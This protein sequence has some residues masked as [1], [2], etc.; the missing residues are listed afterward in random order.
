MKKLAVL[1]IL[2]LCV[3]TLGGCMSSG[4]GSS[5]AD[6]VAFIRFDATDD[7]N[8]TVD[9]DGKVI[10]VT[11]GVNDSTPITKNETVYKDT[12]L[13]EKDLKTALKEIFK[14]SDKTKSVGIAIV[15]ATGKEDDAVKS[16]KD[17]ISQYLD[18][19]F[20]ANESGFDVKIQ[21]SIDGKNFTDVKIISAGDYDVVGDETTLEAE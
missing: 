13:V 11:C 19:I 3:V 10:A 17:K 8:L 6:A 15:S 7:V 16:V 20:K 9:K 4:A 12:Q 1:M 2:V 5:V 18:E 21:F 14:L